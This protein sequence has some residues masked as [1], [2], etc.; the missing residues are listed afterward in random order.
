MKLVARTTEPGFA[1]S[2]LRTERTIALI[3]IT[4]LGIVIAVYLSSPGFGRILGSKAVVVLELACVYAFICL[5][6]SASEEGTSIRLRLAT[7]LIDVGLITLWITATGGAQSEFWSLYLIAVASVGLRFGFAE[8]IGVAFGLAILHDAFLLGARDVGWQTLVYRPM[9]IVLAGF[10]VGV[11]SYHLAAQ[12]RERAAVEEIAE[13]RT[14][15]LGK[16]REEVA[17]L[18]R[19]DLARTELMAVAAHE[20]RTPLAAILGVLDT[21][22]DHGAALD[23]RL[24]TELI[25]GAEGQA[26]RLSRLVEDLLTMSRI[27]DGVLRLSMV[28]ADARELV[29]DAARAAGREEQVVI[30]VG[31]VGSVVCDEDAVVRVL[32]NLLDNAGKYAPSEEPITVLVSRVGDR[33]RFAVRDHG[34]GV[35]PEERES[36][37][38]RFRRLDGSGRPGTGLGLYIARGLVDAHDGELSAGEAPGGGAEFSFWL[39]TRS[40]GDHTVAVRRSGDTESPGEAV[41]MGGARQIPLDV[42]Q[43]TA[44]AGAAG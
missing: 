31:A 33:V 35:P 27:E 9:I 16:E 7:L 15:E 44:P 12:R 14:L 29:A 36:V 40:P 5:L 32:T 10:A 25:D 1:A 24:R 39:P 21:L 22:R 18:R 28:E 42:N 26:E 19:V 17:R 23:D 3:R 11:L 6:V 41:P 4:V 30:E 2:T 13:S 43:V 38:D 34:P 37:F 8:T 20:L